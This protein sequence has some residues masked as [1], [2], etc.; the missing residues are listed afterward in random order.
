MDTSGFIESRLLHGCAQ[1][2]W[3][4]RPRN[5][6]LPTGELAGGLDI[7]V[8][9]D[10]IVG[11]V[12]SG[13]SGVPHEDVLHWPKG[14]LLPGLIDSHAHLTF[15]AD[16][17]VVS[18][19]IG[20]SPHR[21]VAR[22]FGN[23]Q[24]A[25][26][27]GVTTVV[28]CGGRTEVML[29][30]RQASES[31]LIVSPT[32]LVSGAPITTTAGHCH[33]IGGVA[34]TTDEVIR[35]ARQ[36]VQD[37]VD[38]IKVMLTGGNITAGSN[39]KQLQYPDATI[40]A[41]GAEC[42]RLGKPLVVHAHSE[43]AV[44]LAAR[45]AATVIAHASCQ[46]AEGKVAL[47]ADTVAALTVAGTSVDATITVGDLEGE[48]TADPAV[49]RRNDQRTAM[50][51]LF[52]RMH[53]AGVTVL[54]G[55]D[56]G[57]PG[58]HHGEVGRAIIALHREVGIPLGEAL[59]S[60]T[61]HPAEVFGRGERLGVIQ[62]DARADLLLLEGDVTTD[63]A[64]VRRPALVWMKGQLVSRSGHLLAGAPAPMLSSRA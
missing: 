57:V 38:F 17:E 29:T 54:A 18:N 56:G 42:Q 31:G 4:I 58:V 21:Q 22:A 19:A 46:D 43:H 47:S 49:Q 32:V 44:S 41:L 61:K 8:L 55:T 59:L 53:E 62:A 60:G 16:G 20:D 40:A 6:L 39:P 48:T 27:K 30:V 13:E 23:A 5:V 11:V 35:L 25:L 52:R 26:T 1:G 10:S 28:D 15:S 12:G 7:V 64:A 51:P 34:D 24:L 36:L 33:W 3:A 37:G 50:L 14:T 63:I 45:C 2:A 9:G